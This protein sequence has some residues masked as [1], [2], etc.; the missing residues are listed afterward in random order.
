M[1]VS[2]IASSDAI[3][4]D[5]ARRGFR[6]QAGTWPIWVG[7]EGALPGLLLNR[8]AFSPASPIMVVWQEDGKANLSKNNRSPPPRTKSTTGPSKRRQLP[9]SHGESK[10]KG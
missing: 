2:G 1:P 9:R 10:G 6:L 3:A 5:W 8:A 4:L 7:G